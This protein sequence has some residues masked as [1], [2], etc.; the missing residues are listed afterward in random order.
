MTTGVKMSPVVSQRGV[1][2]GNLKDRSLEIRSVLRLFFFY[3][4]NGLIESI[5]SPNSSPVFL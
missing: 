1:D 3:L 5:V 2:D 4:R